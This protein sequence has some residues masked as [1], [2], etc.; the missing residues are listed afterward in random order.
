[1]YDKIKKDVLLGSIT[2]TYTH[3]PRSSLMSR[4]LGH[5]F[6]LCRPQYLFARIQ[7]RDPVPHAGL[8]SRY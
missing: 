6:R 2:G 3:R 1:V 5:M 7:G 8:C 4:R